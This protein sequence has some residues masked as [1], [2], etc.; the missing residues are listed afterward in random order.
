MDVIRG[1]GKNG[2]LKA[3]SSDVRAVVTGEKTQGVMKQFRK[4]TVN[5]TDVDRRKLPPPVLY[6]MKT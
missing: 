5:I 1:G 2:R 3:Q 6:L 4:N